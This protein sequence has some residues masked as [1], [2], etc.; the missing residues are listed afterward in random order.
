[1]M[2]RNHRQEALCR[3]YVR[4]IAAQAG[5]LCGQPD[6]DDGID[7]LLRAVEVDSQRR[8][9]ASLQLD[10]QLRSTTRA[11]LTETA[12]RYDL[13]VETYNDLRIPGTCPRILVVLVLP[14]D[15]AEW[16]RQSPDELALRRC[17]YWLSLEGWTPSEATRSVRIE[18]PLANVFSAEAV[19]ALMQQARER[20]RR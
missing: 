13:D 17:A 19:G 5:V 7:L 6:P 1:M 9:D 18:I 4:A 12:V 2:T 15:E 20:S 11:H 10:L 16:V 14:D 3:V 8:R